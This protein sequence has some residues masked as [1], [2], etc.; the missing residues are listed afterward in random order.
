MPNKHS[1]CLHPGC[2]RKSSHSSYMYIK[3]QYYSKN[4]VHSSTH[5]DGNFCIALQ[6]KVLVRRMRIITR[7]PPPNVERR[8][9][10][11][12]YNRQFNGFSLFQKSF[13]SL[14][15]P[16]RA[17]NA[18]PLVPL[19]K[20]VN[21]SLSFSLSW[22]TVCCLA[23]LS[24]PLSSQSACCCSRAVKRVRYSNGPNERARKEV[25]ERER[26]WKSE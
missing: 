25:E 14:F 19:W 18:A 2:P 3:N 13:E 20:E 24:L 5:T 6:N 17:R 8:A 1:Y 9:S 12:G 21:A 4:V 11:P 22:G 7:R 16:A 15:R 26:R 23:S 10:F